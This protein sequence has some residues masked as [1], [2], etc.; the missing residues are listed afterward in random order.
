MN[1]MSQVLE[2]V[3]EADSG[4][5]EIT[6]LLAATKALRKTG[7][8]PMP[9]ALAVSPPFAG[10]T[11]PWSTSGAYC[12][13]KCKDIVR[14]ESPFSPLEYFSGVL[15]VSCATFISCAR[16]KRYYPVWLPVVLSLTISWTSLERPTFSWQQCQ[17]SRLVLSL[18]MPC[19]LLKIFTVST[20]SPG[21][22]VR[23]ALWF[24]GSES[25]EGPEAGSC[26]GSC[27]GLRSVCHL[28]GQQ[29]TSPSNSQILHGV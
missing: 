26:I 6:T 20:S 27:C 15:P 9:E 19:L 2:T 7:S 17:Y 18:A 3:R 10:P 5:A 1:S 11:I 29:C 16:S 13:L 22:A 28:R 4:E 8:R 23:I 14:P 24:A 21:C 25:W 12:W